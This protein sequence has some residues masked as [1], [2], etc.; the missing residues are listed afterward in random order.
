MGLLDV[1]PSHVVGA[2]TPR[3]HKRERGSVLWFQGRALGM[4]PYVALCELCKLSALCAYSDVM[5]N[6]KRFAKNQCTVMTFSKSQYLWV[7]LLSI[8]CYLLSITHSFLSFCLLI[9]SFIPLCACLFIFF[10]YLYLV[11]NTYLF[12]LNSLYLFLSIYLFIYFF[13]YH[14]FIYLFYKFLYH[15][16]A[17]FYWIIYAF[18]YKTII[19]FKTFFYCHP[20][21]TSPPVQKVG[22][23]HLGFTCS[24]PIFTQS[25]MIITVNDVIRHN[26]ATSVVYRCLSTPVCLFACFHETY[27]PF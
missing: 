6:E 10:I 12:L 27:I 13:I 17:Y 8:F 16:N 23:V 2:R 3:N 21:L 14:L 19:L 4:A 5:N 18:I 22:L 26:E 25:W 7:F 20:I 9:H 15:V 11:L 1:S 24:F